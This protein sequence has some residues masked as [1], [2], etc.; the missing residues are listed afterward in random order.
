MTDWRDKAGQAKNTLTYL[1]IGAEII[2]HDRRPNV[3]PTRT[4]LGVVESRIYDRCFNIQETRDLLGDPLIAS[5]GISEEDLTCFCDGLV[6]AGLMMREG[7]KW[8]ALALPR[9]Y[10]MANLD[11]NPTDGPLNEV[12]EGAPAL[13]S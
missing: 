5:F 10:K 4:C 6:A 2:I 9:R 8:L 7:N 1:R 11:M 12:Q 13:V 3:T